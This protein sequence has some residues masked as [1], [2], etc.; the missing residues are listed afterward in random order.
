M[1][2]RG[3]VSR[4]ES[5]FTSKRA[6]RGSVE[7]SCA[8]AAR[9]QAVCRREREVYHEHDDGA[10]AACSYCIRGDARNSAGD[11]MPR[12]TAQHRPGSAVARRK[13][14]PQVLVAATSED[15]IDETLEE[16]F[17]ASDPPSWTLLTRIGSPR[18]RPRTLDDPE[19]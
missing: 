11:M 7:A 6:P 4:R 5:A 18:R 12:S 3:L 10:W 16:S 19:T 17:P 9:S 2:R 15:K 14:Q 8:G 13:R 1:R